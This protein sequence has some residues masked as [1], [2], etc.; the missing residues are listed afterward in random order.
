[1]THEEI[2]KHRL[3][4][5]RPDGKPLNQL[6]WA[7]LLGAS[8][9]VGDYEL[10]PSEKNAR[11]VP[12]YIAQSVHFFRLLEKSAPDVAQ[13]EISKAIREVSNKK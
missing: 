7:A 5:K 13:Q 8:K 2:L 4:T 12:P 3:A 1:M 6:E 10:P 9:K 11:N